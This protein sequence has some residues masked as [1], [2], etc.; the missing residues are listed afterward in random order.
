MIEEAYGLFCSSQ[1]KISRFPSPGNPLVREINLFRTRI[2]SALAI[3]VT[4]ESWG[5]D[6]YQKKL[7][8]AD[9]N[10]ATPTLKKF[11]LG[12]IRWVSH[13]HTFSIRPGNIVDPVNVFDD[14]KFVLMHNGS[15]VFSQ[16]GYTAEKKDFY[17]RTEGGELLELWI[18]DPVA[19]AIPKDNFFYVD[20]DIF[21][22]PEHRLLE[23]E[24]GNQ[25]HYQNKHK[26]AKI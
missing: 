26:V 3:A 14:T 23:L 22:E 18:Y 25:T 24:S 10:N 9:V 7:L 20:V 6:G 2:G 21:L 19:I 12:I 5:N 13:K 15:E 16:L 1:G 11:D 8:S 17:W 4:Y